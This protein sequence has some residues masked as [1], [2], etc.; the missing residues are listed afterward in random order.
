MC[1]V[2]HQNIARNS[3]RVKYRPTRSTSGFLHL[4]CIPSAAN[5]IGKPDCVNQVF[6]AVGV[7]PED[8]NRAFSLFAALEGL[9]THMRLAPFNPSVPDNSPYSAQPLPASTAASTPL[10]T[11]SNTPV[12]QPGLSVS[13][14]PQPAARPTG[15][16]RFGYRF[17]SE[18]GS[19]PFE[20]GR[21]TPASAATPAGAGQHLHADRR[22]RFVRF[23]LSDF[24]SR[25]STERTRVLAAGSKL[26][27]PAGQDVVWLAT[28]LCLDWQYS[29]L[30]NT[31]MLEYD[32][33]LKPKIQCLVEASNPAVV[34]VDLAYG[35]VIPAGGLSTRNPRSFPVLDTLLSKPNALI[36]T[37]DKF[38]VRKILTCCKIPFTPVAGALQIQNTPNMTRTISAC[39]RI[40]R[41][42][43]VFWSG[44]AVAPR[45]PSQV[46]HFHELDKQS[47]AHILNFLCINDIPLTGS[48]TSALLTSQQ[49]PLQNAAFPAIFMRS[50][51]SR[52][53][54]AMKLFLVSLPGWRDLQVQ[55]VVSDAQFGALADKFSE[56]ALMSD[57][58]SSFS[59]DGD[60]SDDGVGA[61]DTSFERM[62]ENEFVFFMRY[63]S[64][65]T[66]IIYAE[67][68]A[69]L[70]E[71]E[72][73]SEASEVSEE[74][75]REE[76]G[77]S[78]E[79]ETSSEEED[80]VDPSDLRRVLPRYYAFPE[81]ED[82]HKECVICL[83]EFTECKEL[84]RLPCLCEFH[85]DCIIPWVAKTGMC[86][87]DRT[88]VQKVLEDQMQ[89]GG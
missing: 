7:S 47:V 58:N 61:P 52:L 18:P 46:A 13:L 65:F 42:D 15:D 40:A 77:W 32:V 79:E 81:S 3:V 21:L 84:T 72:D 14:P 24:L 34:E 17:P 10:Q 73:A 74:E 45:A 82:V 80:C 59:D 55:E 29:P 66:R 26:H 87:N 67:D 78:Q 76:D 57:S 22:V 75:D 56:A 41:A 2:C 23:A 63:E 31:V 5:I 6:V 50:F 36:H 11:Q 51:R 64:G 16:A 8:R 9:A 44:E 12:A 38:C 54:L 69:G 89:L 27:F 53:T 49:I 70:F 1:R 62:V 19:L 68:E 35:S 28:A 71:G 83:E 25:C 30:T 4:E 20:P 39:L 43:F 88:E 86:P 48:H 33:V 60:A 37:P 85:S